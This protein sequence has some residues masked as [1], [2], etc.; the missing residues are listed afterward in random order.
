MAVGPSQPEV[1]QTCTVLVVD[2]DEGIREAM[3][4]VLVDEGHAVVTA[5]NGS[6]A[7]ERLRRGLRPELILLDLMMPVMDGRQFRAEQ[8]A[9]PTLRTIPV[10]VITA[11]GDMGPQAE[12]GVQAWLEKPIE[13][14][15]LLEEIRKRR[16]VAA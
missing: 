10:V 4:A 13:L 16:P 6:E 7:L 15:R 8:L 3:G 12:M 14:D 11:G 2:D 9:D 1:P 5:S